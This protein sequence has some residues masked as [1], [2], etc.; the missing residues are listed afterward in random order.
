M[1]VKVVHFYIQ[2]TCTCRSEKV[3]SVVF[4]EIYSSC[5]QL[6]VGTVARILDDLVIYNV[7]CY[8]QHRVIYNVRLS[9]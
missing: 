8:L 7:I 1:G 5:L 4:L 2:R 6:H 9:E 3:A